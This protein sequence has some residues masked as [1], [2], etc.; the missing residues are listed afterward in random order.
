MH[1]IVKAIN[2]LKYGKSDENEGLWSDHLIH[3]TH[4][5]YVMLTFLFNM[6]LVHCIGNKLMFLYTMVP[7][8]KNKKKCGG[9]YILSGS[10]HLVVFSVKHVF[11]LFMSD[12]VKG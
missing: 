3:G 1:D 6:V 4:N 10:V 7:I 9:I 11:N 8:P 2:H 12:F 5:L